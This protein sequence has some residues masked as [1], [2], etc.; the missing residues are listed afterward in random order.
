MISINNGA[1]FIKTSTGKAKV[2]ATLEAA[3]VMLNCIRELN[4]NCGF[5]AAGGIRSVSVAQEYLN[6]ACEIMGDKWVNAKHMRIGA[7]ELLD[8]ILIDMAK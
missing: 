2:N 6:L 7:S 4:S 5:K 8:N 3:K 1:D